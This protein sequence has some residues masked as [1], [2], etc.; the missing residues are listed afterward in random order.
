MGTARRVI[1]GDG[2]IWESEQEVMGFL[3]GKYRGIQLGS[4][5]HPWPSLDGRY[6]IPVGGLAAPQTSAKIWGGF[7]DATGIE[8]A[9]V[10]PT[11][12]LAHGL[13]Q[14]RDW[15]V[16]LSRAYNNWLSETYLKADARIKSL[17][18]LPV[19]DVGEAVRD[20][21][22]GVEQLGVVGGLLPAVTYNRKPY[23]HP[24]FLPII[25]EAERLDV[26]LAVHAGP[27]SHLGLEVFDKHIEAH[28]LTHPVPIM[29]HLIS[30][31]Y[32]GVFEKCPNVR[33]VFLE[34]GAGWIPFIMERMDYEYKAR[35]G[36]APDLKRLPSEAIRGGNVYVSCEN[37]EKL[38]PVVAGYLGED[39]MIF[40][41]DFPHELAY[42]GY[43]REAA[44]FAERSDLSEPLK[45]KILADNAIRLYNL[46][47]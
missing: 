25:R 20:L 8:K 13:I 34:A 15:A 7:L 32:N 12:G 17:A 21:R 46:D 43:I 2:H 1:D 36:A 10:Y 14:D 47:S 5:F 28:V 16:A 42:E 45:K 27:Q 41:T 4:V 29:G 6:R 26:P 33:V 39:R 9:V 23:G 18:L 22:R 19:Q 37:E 35:P 11:G 38:L 24:D 31:V 40:A 30:M 44:E 3:E